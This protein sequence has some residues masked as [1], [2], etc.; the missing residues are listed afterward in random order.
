[1]C[2]CLKAKTIAKKLFSVFLKQKNKN[3]NNA[4]KYLMP[5]DSQRENMRLKIV[6]DL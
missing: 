1:M 4:M 6:S 5:K 3:K 2:L